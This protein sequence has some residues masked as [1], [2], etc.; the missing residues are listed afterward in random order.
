LIVCEIDLYLGGGWRFVMR[1]PDGSEHPFKGVYREI[2]PNKRLVYT[3]C[4]DVPAIGSPEWL[5]TIIFE[6]LDGRTKLTHSILHATTEARDGHLKAGMEAG[7][8]QTLNRLAKQ[9]SLMAE[10]GV[11]NA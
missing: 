7:M 4:Y 5:T 6:E 11:T 10:A 2:V 3:E 8:V 9:I 1:M